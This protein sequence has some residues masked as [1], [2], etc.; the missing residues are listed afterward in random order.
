MKL[1]VINGC[2]NSGKDSFA[3]FAC[4]SEYPVYNFSTVDFIKEKALEMGWDGAKDER[5]RRLL[6]DIKDALSLYDDIPFKKVLEKIKQVKEENAIIFVHSR[7]PKDIAH[8]VEQ[9]QAKTLFIRRP[10]AEDEEHN[11]HADKEVFNYDYDYVY[12]N[13]G[14]LSDLKEEAIRFVNWIG[15]KQ[16]ES[17]VE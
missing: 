16:W 15:E 11:N 14:S 13:E 1:I 9:T 4:E 8:W 2:A 6:S 17:V 7:E 5:G 10:A 3:N 12:S